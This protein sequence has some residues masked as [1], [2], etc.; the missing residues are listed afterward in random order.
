MA[1]GQVMLEVEGRGVREL[2]DL[3]DFRNDRDAASSVLARL[4]VPRRAWRGALVCRGGH[5]LPS[6]REVCPGDVVTVRLGGLRG[7]GGDGGSTGAED[8]R[9]WLEMFL[10]KKPDKVD[11]SEMKRAKWTRCAAEPAPPSPSDPAVVSDSVSSFMPRVL[12]FPLP[13][14]PPAGVRSR[15]R[16]SPRLAWPTALAICTTRRPW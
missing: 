6:L 10:E 14:R 7:G 15:A 2:V 1:R 3:N 4:G 5:A 9:A 13:L 8:R 12:P 16:G 11:P